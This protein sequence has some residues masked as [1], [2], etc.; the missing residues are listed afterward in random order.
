M[1]TK[2]ILWTVVYFVVATLLAMWVGK[3]IAFGTGS[4]GEGHVE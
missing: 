2:I 3:F 1:V 4:K